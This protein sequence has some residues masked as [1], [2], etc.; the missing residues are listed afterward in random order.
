MSGDQ[1]NFILTLAL[2]TELYQEDILN[3][4]LEIARQIYNS[5]LGELFKRYN[6]MKQS[7]EYNKAAKRKKGNDRNQ[8]FQQLNKKYGLTEYSLH[9]FV[10]PMQHKFKKNIDSFTAQKIATRCFHAF[11]EF[12]FHKADRVY[13]KKY[14]E[15]NSVEGKSNK[16]GINFKNNEL[17]WNK[18]TIPLII[19]KKDIYAQTALQNKVKYCRVVRKFIRGKYKFYLQLILDGA[20][21][22]KRN[23]DT[24][25]V[26]NRIGAND[27]GIDIGTQTIAI[28]SRHEVKLLELAP[29][30]N[31]IEK[32]K[33]T[34]NRKLDR[35]RRANNPNKY[36]ADG[37]IKRGNRDKWM[38]SNRYIQTQNKVREL[39]RKQADI[40]KQ[41]HEKLA[42]YIIGLGN[43]VK[44]EAMNYKGLQARAK[45]TT[46]NDKTGRMNK[47]KRFGK[48]V[49][50]K[51][52]AMF[53][54]I[55]DNK[56]KWHG[57]VLLKIDTKKVKASQ[58]NHIEDN[59]MK[60][61]LSER[62]NDFGDYKVQRDLY[63]AY[64][65][66]NVKESLKEIDRDL[67]FEGF[68]NFKRLHDKEILRIKNDKSKR[69]SSMGI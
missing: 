31:N 8:F 54:T 42:N 9:D 67:C 33:R 48:S 3:K 2:K 44:V 57:K 15:M 32:Q 50:N 14:G 53:L 13:F 30:I 35:Q 12:M 26:K 16:T 65:I 56:L 45:E 29:E 47:K 20:P 27:V 7:R 18:L 62:W 10:K 69:I 5:C 24:G 64:L 19:K 28:A 6:F 58:Y 63:S 46:V 11:K 4:R 36:N 37:T 41:S 59:Y 34:L 49:A 68:E 61:P 51:A 25:E 17:V 66:K 1:S 23:K 21:P 39:Q 55:L 22:L 60:K 40:R 38:K 43:K 52:P